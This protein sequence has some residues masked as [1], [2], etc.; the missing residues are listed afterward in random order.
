MFSDSLQEE[1]VEQAAVFSD[2]G[3]GKPV[4]LPALV[5]DNGEE[6]PVQLPGI[7][8]AVPS[9]DIFNAF[10]T[11][12]LVSLLLVLPVA[13]DIE[14]EEALTARSAQGM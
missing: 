6:K 4:Q 2:T 1:G 10:V 9:F 7:L 5:S 12:S 14:D 3:E 8:H 11:L 13:R